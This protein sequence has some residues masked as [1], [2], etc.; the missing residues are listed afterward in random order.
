MNFKLKNFQRWCVD[1]SRE[2]QDL[3]LVPVT[4]VTNV[5]IWNS[6]IV[7]YIL[8]LFCSMYIYM[9]PGF[10]LITLFYMIVFFVYIWCSNP[11]C[12]QKKSDRKCQ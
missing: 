2:L 6:N 8:C 1:K 5:L 4:N 7:F 11:R 3:D 9:F 12:K 10:L